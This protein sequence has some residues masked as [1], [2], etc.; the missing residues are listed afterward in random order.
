MSIHGIS[1]IATQ[2]IFPPAA[3]KAQARATPGG[4]QAG[5]GQMVRDA[6]TTVDDA[7]HRTAVSIQDLLSGKSQDVLPVVAQVAEA[8]MSF[9]LLMGVRNKVIE[10][11]KA[12]I[13]MQI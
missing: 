9:K 7:Q 2:P 1:P 4:E 3:E 8:D 10:A 6:V 12:T 13:N 11:Y 5:F